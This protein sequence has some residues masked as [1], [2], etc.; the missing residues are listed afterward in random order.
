M[1]E[2]EETIRVEIYDRTYNLRSAEEENYTRQ[3][4]KAVDAA[5]RT[6]AEQTQMVDSLNVA[7]LAALH[8][9]DRYER[10]KRRYD[11]LNGA[12]TEKTDRIRRALEAASSG[13]A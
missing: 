8:Y 5:M 10:L 12:V 13:A 1:A 11:K 6:I 3:L 2:F 9:A 4:A 7:V